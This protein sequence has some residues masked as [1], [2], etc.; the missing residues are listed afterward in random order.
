LRARDRRDDRPRARIQAN[1]AAAPRALAGL[2]GHPFHRGGLGIGFPATKPEPGGLAMRRIMLTAAAM[3]VA[4]STATRAEEPVKL[5]IGWITVPISL[6]PIF[7]AKKDV[8]KHYGQSYTLQPIHFAGSTPQITALASGDLDIAEL[9]YSSL[10]IAIQNAHLA[11]LRMIADSLQ[12][13][14]KPG[15]YTGPFVVLKDGPVKKIEDLKGKS[16]SVNVIGAGID[17]AMR[18]MLR[19]HGLE[20]QRDYNVVEANFVNQEQLLTEGKVAMT[21]TVSEMVNDPEFVKATRSLFTLRDAMG[22]PTQILMRAAREGDIAKKRAA[23]VDFFEDE[24]REWRWYLDPKNRAEALKIVA[25][26][27]KKPASF[28]DAYIWKADKDL[29]HDPDDKPNVEALGRNIKAQKEAGFLNIDIDAAKISDLSIVEE[30][31]KRVHAA[32]AK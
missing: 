5:T 18:A 13:G 27:N 22:G 19:K 24:I 2:S 17:I 7:E 23:F 21:T 29:Y 25:D 14:V 12:D 4:L 8:T 11:D 9:S 30:A 16:V 3:L 1:D 31:A 10:A 26:F 32:A 15:S 28:Y 20:A 6:A